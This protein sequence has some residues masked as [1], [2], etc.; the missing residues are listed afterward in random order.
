MTENKI[1]L[2][3]YDLIY[4]QYY[5][6]LIYVARDLIQPIFC[7]VSVCLCVSHRKFVVSVRCTS[8]VCVLVTQNLLCRSSVR[9]VSCDA[10]YDH[11]FC[12]NGPEVNRKWTGN[13]RKWA[14]SVLEVSICPSVHPKQF[15]Y[16]L[17][18]TCALRFLDSELTLTPVQMCT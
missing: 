15:P 6:S 2:K 14:R 17:D 7:F 5:W 13:D 9:P 8:S 1:F 12:P 4:R 10:S 16:L 3:S 18:E 11:L